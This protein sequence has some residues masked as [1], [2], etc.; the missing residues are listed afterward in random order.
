M[1]EMRSVF[2]GLNYSLARVCANSF[3]KPFDSADRSLVSS[4][5]SVAIRHF[6][7]K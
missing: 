6:K 7:V 3:A 1:L 2:S 4:P 5:Y